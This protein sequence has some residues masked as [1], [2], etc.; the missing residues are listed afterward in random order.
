M[1]GNWGS[2]PLSTNLVQEAIGCTLEQTLINPYLSFADS[3]AN[4]TSS[5][6][7]VRF[8]LL[9]EWQTHRN[10]VLIRLILFVLT[11]NLFGEL[12]VFVYESVF[13]SIS[14]RDFS[15]RYE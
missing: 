7:R 5:P 14:D 3:L 4:T 2:G 9:L 8:A 11:G 1:G 12:F 15:N 10:Y 6:N 13:I